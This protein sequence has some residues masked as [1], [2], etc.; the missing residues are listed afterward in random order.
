VAAPRGASFD[1]R[2]RPSRRRRRRRRRF[3]ALGGR[4]FEHTEF[5]AAAVHPDG[6]QLTLA[7]A[8]GAP[9]ALGDANRPSAV[10]ALRQG[11][12]GGGGGEP[13]AHVAGNGNGRKAALNGSG[14]GGGGGQ[15]GGD[16][17]LNGGSSG[18]RALNGSSNGTA[19]VP[20]HTL[21]GG[22]GSSSNGARPAAAEVG[23]PAPQ[24]PPH[25]GRPW[26]LRARLMLDCMGHYSPV[27]KQIRG[28]PATA[29][30]APARRPIQPPRWARPCAR[31]RA[32]PGPGAA[33]A[34]LFAKSPER[35]RPCA[36]CPSPPLPPA[37]KAK[38]EGMCLVV[39]GCA[40]GFPPELN[41]TADLLY[42]FTDSAADMQL[43]WEAF[44]AGALHACSGALGGGA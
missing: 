24:P 39:G 44:P 6:L 14:D 8:R 1:C 11:G 12:G 26:K 28:T 19:A 2:T 16:G 35:I 36:T 15:C 33:P 20:A 38:P 23:G 22:S 40:D 10:E 7:P 4:V 9:L 31:A 29:P 37:G 27:V 41:R 34:P 21:N 43:F 17:G 42:S 25:Q 3:E 13:W 32:G 18:A 5:R 30:R